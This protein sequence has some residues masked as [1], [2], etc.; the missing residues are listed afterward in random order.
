MRPLLASSKAASVQKKQTRTSLPHF[1]CL[2]LSLSPYSLGLKR[3]LF[4]LYI[5][6][7][8]D[9][10]LEYS[11][12]GRYVGILESYPFPQR[13]SSAKAFFVSATLRSSSSKTQSSTI[14]EPLEPPRIGTDQG[15]VGFVSASF[16]TEL[17]AEKQPPSVGICAVDASPSL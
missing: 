3:G 5:A 6:E 15:L 17:V 4:I 2:L 14:C 13:C 9:D 1:P 8:R 11:R 12:K 16:A 7:N 10:S